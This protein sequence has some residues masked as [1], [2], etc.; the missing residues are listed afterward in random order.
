GELEVLP[1]PLEDQDRAPDL[2]RGGLQGPTPVA[3]DE[4]ERLGV[5]DQAFDHPIEIAGGDDLIEAAEVGDDV[6]G[7]V[8]GLS[9]GLNDLQIAV[10]AAVGAHSVDPHRHCTGIIRDDKASPRGK[11]AAPSSG[12]PSVFALHFRGRRLAASCK[13]AYVSY[14]PPLKSAQYCRRWV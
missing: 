11:K 9:P 3:L 2:V 5:G 6:L 1:E 10:V 14:A 12:A 7:D 8:A 4:L 13:T